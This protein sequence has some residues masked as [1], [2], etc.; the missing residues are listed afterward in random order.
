[1]KTLKLNDKIIR[2]ADN[3]TNRFLKVGYTFVPKS[4]WKTKVRD[5]NKTVNVEVTSD[6]VVDKKLAKRLKLKEKQD[7]TRLY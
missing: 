7:G 3:D 1:M 6:A 2:V 5:A 4:E